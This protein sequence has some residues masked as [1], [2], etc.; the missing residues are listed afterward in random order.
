MWTT[1]QSSVYLPLYCGIRTAP[2]PFAAGVATLHRF[3]WDSAFW[4]FNIV[5]NF[6][7]SRYQ[8]MIKDVHTVQREL[9]AEFLARQPDIDAAALKLYEQ[10]PESA[11]SYLT[12]Y[13]AAQTEKVMQHW[14]K[15]LESLVV[16]YMDRGTSRTNSA[17]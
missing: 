8:D 12:E 14:R 1:R 16:K 3:S 17:A 10:S 7:Y 4:M 9:E 2:H 5:A 13:A 6:T 11:R 15:L